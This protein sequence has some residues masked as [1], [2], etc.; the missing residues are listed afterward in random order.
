MVIQATPIFRRSL[1]TTP[2]MRKFFS[3]LLCGG[4]GLAVWFAPI[5]SGISVNAWHLLAIFLFTILGLIIKP[6]PMGGLAILSLTLIMMTGT[7]TVSEALSGFTN[8]TVW[9]IVM[10]FFI[11]RGFIKTGFGLR[12]AYFLMRLF[13]KS[14]LG[15]AYAMALTDIVLAPTIPSVT[16][17][18]GGVVF[19]VVTSLAKAFGSEPR[20]NPRK[21]GAF[22]IQAVFQTGAITSAMFL[23][24]M[25]GN[26][27]I[28]ELAEGVGISISWGSWAIAAFVPGFISL[29]VVPY[30][31]YKLYPPEKKKT[32]EA[33]EIASTRLKEMGRMTQKE[34][35]MIGAFI[36]LVSLWAFG[37]NLGLD[38]TITAM[39]GLSILLAS[40]VLT[41]ENVLEEKGAWD[42]LIWFS[43]LITM[44]TYLNKLGLMHWF[45]DQVMGHVQGFPWL[46]GFAI[47]ALI[48]FY[49]HY[50]FASN[51]AHISAMYPPFLILSIALGTPPALAA[52][53][54]GFFSSLFG[55]LTQYGSGPAPILFG[56]GY[57]PIGKWWQIGLYVSIVNIFIWAFVGGL[58]WKI[59]GLY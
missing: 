11:A 30:I 52:L 29:A 42:T 6:L 27:M 39:I 38:A 55:T 31:V 57:V 8:N 48:Y 13:G 44:A 19:P 22:L 4:V 54:L 56:A 45:S 59:L 16:A 20:T 7:L 58:W 50:F 23:T 35:V 47:L 12:I 26:P 3:F 33:R 36:L 24:A 51:L 53:V 34:W 28:A 5:P 2:V 25:A 49:S 1:V 17:R 15:M 41:W 32:P 37:R 43:I 10:A 40:N 46:G 18:A 9:L 14:T 21:I